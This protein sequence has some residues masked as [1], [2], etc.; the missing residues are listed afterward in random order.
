MRSPHKFWLPLAFLVA[1]AFACSSFAMAQSAGNA[2]TPSPP[3]SG[4][5][6]GVPSGPKLRINPAETQAPAPTSSGAKNDNSTGAKLRLGTTQTAPQSTA[7][8]PTA[9]PHPAD[10]NSPESESPSLPTPQGLADYSGTL[11]PGKIRLTLVTKS[12][13]TVTGSYFLPP[14]FSDIKVEGR[15]IDAHSLSLREVRTDVAEDGSIYLK[16]TAFANSDGL[17]GTW[18]SRDGKTSLSLTL[19]LEDAL[20]GVTSVETRY[21]VTGAQDPDALEKNVQAFYAAVLAN[22]PEQ[23]AAAVSFPLAY[24]A[25]GRRTLLHKPSDFIAKY[26]AIFTPEFVAQIR[27]T[28]PHQMLANDQG[29]ILG[30]GL[31]WFNQDGKAFALNN[32]P[33]KM[34]AGRQFLTNAGWKG[35][36]SISSGNPSSKSPKTTAAIASQTGLIA[37][38]PPKAIPNATSTHTTSTSSKTRRRRHG[39]RSKAAAAT[40]GQ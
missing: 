25:S 24:T 17:A 29:V 9:A 10:A 13:G 15:I 33:V 4:S 30:A 39:K 11:G 22:A 26:S 12:D 18:A 31:V 23:A 20:P 40:S 14:S 28:T 34:F 19:Q 6:T 5:T 8:L 27:N 3:P 1:G 2:A 21:A 32:E 35:A 16:K 7:P 36:A 37:A 38:A